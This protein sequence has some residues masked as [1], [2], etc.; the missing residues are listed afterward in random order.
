MIPLRD[1]NP[2]HRT[3]VVTLAIIAINVAI[4]LYET[5]LDGQGQLEP[6][7]YTWAVIPAELTRDF[8][9]E[10][11]TLISAM[12]MHGGW[13]H[14]L[15]NMLYLWIFGDN[16]EDRLGR[17]RY[18]AFYLTAGLLATAAQVV[19]NPTSSVPNLGASGAI[20]GVLGGYLLLFPSAQVT[21]LVFRFIAQI[22]AYL[23]LGFWFV[24]Q[25][26]PGLV[27]LGSLD[28]ETGGVAFWAH[29]GGFVTGLV[30][31]RPFLLGRRRLDWRC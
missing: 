22:P 18:V 24:F 15:G 13:A 11:P 27:G 12:F 20:A 1:A 29:I 2:T 23:V 8:I 25:L 28:V 19:V 16:I 10:A 14:L 6:F 26:I 7:I 30:L 9:P 21:T 4:F 5:L 31:I 17:A 3:P